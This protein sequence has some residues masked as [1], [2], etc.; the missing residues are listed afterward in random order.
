MTKQFIDEQCDFADWAL[1]QDDGDEVL[2]EKE[3]LHNLVKQTVI[4]TCDKLIEKER[5][6]DGR[7]MTNSISNAVNSYYIN[8]LKKQCGGE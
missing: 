4:A 5:A 3:L 1:I 2:T 8:D 6:V 7:G